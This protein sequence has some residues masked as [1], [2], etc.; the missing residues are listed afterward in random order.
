MTELTLG[1]RHGILEG[2]DVAADVGLKLLCPRGY[3][4]TYTCIRYLDT[5]SL[6]FF[7]QFH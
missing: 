4:V 1:S 3:G 5:F 7:N 2:A 6:D